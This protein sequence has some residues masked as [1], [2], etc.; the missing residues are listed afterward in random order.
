MFTRDLGGAHVLLDHADPLVA[1]PLLSVRIETLEESGLIAGVLAEEVLKLDP[2][3]VGELVGEVGGEAGEDG[4]GIVVH[5]VLTQGGEFSLTRRPVIVPDLLL[6]VPLVA[7]GE[8][9][10]HAQLAEGV[11]GHEI[12]TLVGER[13]LATARCPDVAEGPAETLQLV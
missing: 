2:V 3:V 13:V 10:D 7:V 5:L 8:G 4:T 1:H 12:E 6:A 11:A 9:Q